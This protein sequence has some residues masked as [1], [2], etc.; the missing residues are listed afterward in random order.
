MSF[1]LIA[2]TFSVARDSDHFIQLK[3]LKN[4]GTEDQVWV[5]IEIIGDSKYARAT[6]QSIIDTLEV[7]FFD[8]FEISPYERFEQALKEINII[9]KNIKEKRKKLFGQINAI[10]A[11]FSGNELHLTQCNSAEAYLI[12]NNKFSMISEGLG[13]KSEDLFVNIASGELLPDDKLIFSTARLL[14]L[15]THSQIVQLFNDGVAEAVEMIRELSINDEELSLGAIALHAKLTERPQAIIESSIKNKIWVKFKEYFNVA[16]NFVIE[17]TRGRKKEVNTKKIL[18]AIAAAAL[19]LIISISLLVQSSRNSAIREEY[20]TRIE[21]LNQDIT[22]ANTKGYANDKISANTI[23]DKVEKDARAILDTNYF[24]PEA[25]AILDK[26]QETRDSINNTDRIKEL[27]PYIDLATKNAD[28]KALGIIGLNDNLYAYEYNKLYEIIL[29]Q[30][31]T[32]KPI[33][34]TEIVIGASAMEDQS[35]LVFLTKSGRI[36]E[37]DSGQI[38]FANTE[39]QTWRSGV[40][41]ASYGKNIYILNPDN[42]Q[43]YKYSRLRSK[44]SGASDYNVDADLKDAISMT[45]DGNV[46]IL[47]KGGSILKLY[48]GNQINFKIEDLAVDISDATKIFTTTELDNLYILDAKNKRVV[49][50][51]KPK[52]D[53]EPSRYYGQVIFDELE[54]IQSIYVEKSEKKMYVL[55]DK[56]V[57][58]VDI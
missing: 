41:I 43:I 35:V 54:N 5:A 34:D 56:E 38:K 23:L 28:V 31:L 24:R 37:Y 6:S 48:K 40:D 1:K 12:R 50:V 8:K 26:I 20:R 27:A 49:I 9:I 44:Y 17:K 22:T 36:I 14:R 46:F 18:I 25:L 29:D 7:V 51:T 42:N 53:A 55:T 4:P 11:I 19:I 32:P 47:K 39:D 45:I 13:S 2:D 15:A 33:D 3:T 16:A 10:I 58:R 52:N 57:Y 21:G 30:V